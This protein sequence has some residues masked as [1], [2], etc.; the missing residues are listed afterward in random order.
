MD[1]TQECLD[2]HYFTEMVKI[3]LI[4]KSAQE[5]R[6]FADNH[7]EV[8]AAMTVNE[9]TEKSR[10]FKSSPLSERPVNSG[11]VL[12]N[13]ESLKKVVSGSDK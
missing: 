8:S 6:F 10:R 9:S 3:N 5:I 11:R 13:R 7:Q 4:K 2:L 1:I 12:V